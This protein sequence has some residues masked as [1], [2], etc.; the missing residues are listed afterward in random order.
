MKIKVTQ[1]YNK[2]KISIK[3]K[4]CKS[5][6]TDIEYENFSFEIN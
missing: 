2:T 4:Y 1:R 5:K 3:L 6:Y